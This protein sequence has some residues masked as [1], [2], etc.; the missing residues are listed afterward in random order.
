MGDRGKTGR[1]N[2]SAGEEEDGHRD[3]TPSKGVASAT[4][5]KARRENESTNGNGGRTHASHRHG[6][7]VHPSSHTGL[8]DPLRLGVMPLSR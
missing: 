7:N 4:K 5:R 8:A 1:G 3:R 6:Y 2:E